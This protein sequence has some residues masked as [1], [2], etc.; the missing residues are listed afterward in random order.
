MPPS[1]GECLVCPPQEGLVC[2]PSPGR[3]S[4]PS[5]GENLVCP[6]Q[7]GEGRVWCTLAPVYF[8]VIIVI[9]YSPGAVALVKIKLSPFCLQR[10]SYR[11]TDLPSL[12]PWE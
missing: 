12:T 8:I 5:P 4:V 10:S 9:L 2:R 1:G 11:V 3:S 7:G 6:L